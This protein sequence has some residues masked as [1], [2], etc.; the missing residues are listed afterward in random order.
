[1][2]EERRPEQ[3]L[4]QRPEGC[5]QWGYVL[6]STTVKCLEHVT[7]K[8]ESIPTGALGCTCTGIPCACPTSGN[9]YPGSY[10]PGIVDQKRPGNR[11]MEVTDS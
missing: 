1:M 3:G 11:K 7:Q 2:D 5:S 4:V 6:D 10:F 9:T 8:N